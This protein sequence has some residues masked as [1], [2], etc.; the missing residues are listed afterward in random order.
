MDG[1]HD[2]GGKQGF[3]HVQPLTAARPADHDHRHDHRHDHEE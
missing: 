2:L 1:I 3:G